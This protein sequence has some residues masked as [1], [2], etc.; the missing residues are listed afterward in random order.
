MTKVN[1]N[2]RSCEATGYCVQLVP[3]VFD[4]DD[5]G[6]LAVNEEEAQKVDLAE[7]RE[8]EQMCPTTAISIDAEDAS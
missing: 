3:S 1:V 7:L 4:L 6:N 2:Y 8:A 5:D